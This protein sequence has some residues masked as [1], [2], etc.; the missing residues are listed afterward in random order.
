MQAGTAMAHLLAGRF[1][2]ASSWAE[3]AVSEL[4][5]FLIAVSIVAASH[6]LAGRM[7]EARLAMDHVRRLDPALRISSLQNWLPLHRPEDSLRSQEACGKQG[8][9]NDGEINAGALA[10]SALSRK[11]RADRTRRRARFDVAIVERVRVD[12]RE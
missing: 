1:D 2:A 3:K 9:R 8:C 5:I 11:P 4:P 12:E 10:V 7:E 6:A